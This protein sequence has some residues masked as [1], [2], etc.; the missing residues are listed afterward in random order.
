MVVL[1]NWLH[2][3]D[4]FHSEQG[5]VSHLC[6]NVTKKTLLQC[7]NVTMCIIINQSSLISSAQ[8]IHYNTLECQESSLVSSS[9]RYIYYNTSECQVVRG[10]S[11]APPLSEAGH[12]GV[13]S[14][15][16]DFLRIFKYK[17]YHPERL[18][19]LFCEMQE[20]I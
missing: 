4:F 15:H 6:Y 12:S 1:S 5:H 9:A 3:T 19:H 11:A 16:F 2:P 17:K 8:Y 13:F 7:Y 20:G 14:S 18:P 10:L